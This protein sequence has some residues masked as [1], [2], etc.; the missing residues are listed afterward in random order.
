MVCRAQPN[1]GI[2]EQKGSA[3]E[4]ESFKTVWNQFHSNAMERYQDICERKFRQENYF[5]F[6]CRGVVR[7]AAVVAL[8]AAFSPPQRASV[9]GD[10][11]SPN[12][13]A[14]A[15]TLESTAMTSEPPQCEGTF[16]RAT[17]GALVNT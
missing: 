11:C 5:F 14:T 8:C 10:L 1:R 2:L 16:L 13:R 17:K 15:S 9:S 6:M 3:T 4:L 12:L 7:L